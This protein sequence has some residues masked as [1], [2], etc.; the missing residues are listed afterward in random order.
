MPRRRQGD[1]ET[2]QSGRDRAPDFEEVQMRRNILA[3]ILLAGVAALPSAPAGAQ[4]SADINLH[5]GHAPRAYLIPNTDVYYAPVRN[6]DMYRY[7]STWY[8]DDGGSW[9]AARSYRGPFVNVAFQSVP[10]VILQTPTRYHHQRGY[11]EDRQWQSSNN[12]NN[13]H[14]NGRH[15]G[16]NKNGNN[17]NGNYDNGRNDRNDG[18]RDRDG[19]DN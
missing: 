15:N 16:W 5:F 11:W 18:G 7:G 9:Y 2:S 14:D 13:H 3:A 10:R 19:D 4:V 12:W 8:V 6:Y 17:N 1:P